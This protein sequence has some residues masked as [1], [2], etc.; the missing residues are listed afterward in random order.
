MFKLVISDDEGKT[1]T[2]PLVRDEITIG[3]KEGNTIRLTDRNVSR[4]HARLQKQN[5]HYLLHDLGSYNGTVINGARVADVRTV[6]HGDQIL[7]GDYKLAILEEATA[8]LVSPPAST[9]ADTLEMDVPPSMP[10]PPPAVPGPS[11]VATMQ[12]VPA[13]PAPVSLPPPRPSV[14]PATFAEGE[15][16]DY[17][18]ELRLV[19][20]SPAGAPPPVV[21]ERLP[22]ILGRS[23][24]ADVALPFASISREHA[25]IVCQ[26]GE[27]Y[28]E[29]LASS[30]GLTVNGTKTRRSR[31]GPGDM[32]TMGVVEFRVARRGDSTVVLDRSS[33]PAPKRPPTGLLLAGLGALAVVGV[34]AVLGLRGSNTATPSGSIQELPTPVQPLQPLPPSPA[35]A[36]EP[37]PPPA[38]V[39]APSVAAPPPPPVASPPPSVALPPPPAA[40]VAPEPRPSAPT[41]PPRSSSSS[42]A[43][44]A[45]SPGSTSSARS[46]ANPA[47]PPAPAPAVSAVP[48][49]DAARACLRSG[50]NQCAVNALRDRAQTEP[51]LGLLA[52]T[53]RAMNN[54]AEATRVMRRYLGRFPDGPRAASFRAYLE[55]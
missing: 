6:R 26:D 37:A 27:V 19:F 39:G 31:L 46:V 53:L 54:R 17:V 33:V 5:G 16:P 32:V 3:R 7:I 18:R 51:E 15:M 44:R 55:Q 10:P 11:A 52:V 9:P 14:P 21:L 49:L 2:V 41:P 29:D 48:P 42:S 47:P 13:P 43:S 20:L 40:R 12:G 35:A 38:P 25:R 24:A 50:D 45:S 28:I 23:E 1:T 34:V 30:N 4:R 22:M 8:Q 36:A